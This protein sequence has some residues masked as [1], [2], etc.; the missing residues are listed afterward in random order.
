VKLVT[1]TPGNRRSHFLTNEGGMHA[2]AM[3]STSV[4]LTVS[5][6]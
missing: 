1:S 6:V 3:A 2:K 5:G 4:R